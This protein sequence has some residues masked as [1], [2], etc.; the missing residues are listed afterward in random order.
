MRWWAYEVVSLILNIGA[1]TGMSG[2]VAVTMLIHVAI[3]ITVAVTAMLA[4]MHFDEI[5]HRVA[6]GAAPER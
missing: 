3:R 2:S 4:L 1:L 6:P 5:T